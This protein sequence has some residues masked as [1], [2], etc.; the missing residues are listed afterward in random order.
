MKKLNVVQIGTGHDHAYAPVS[1][2]PKREDIR[3]S[4]YVRVEGETK[5]FDGVPELSYNEVLSMR[6]LDAVFIET[7]DQY[8]TKY[9]HEF[10]KRGIAV[11]MDKPG[12]QDKKSFDALFDLASEKGVPLHLGYMYRYN[13]AIK[14]VIGM[15]KNGDLGEIYYI[16]A[17]MNCFHPDEKRKWLKDYQGGMMNFL[18]CHLVDIVLQVQG[19]PDEIIPYNAASEKQFGED[20]GFAVF[21]YGD[22]CSFIK[23]TAV[24]T[25]GFMRRQI[26]VCGEKGTVEIHPTEYFADHGKL[27]SDVYITLDKSWSYKPD[28]ISFGPYDRYGDM[29]DEFFK[30]V[31]GEMKNPY[32]YEYEKL[33]HDTLLKA[34][35]VK[36]QKEKDAFTKIKKEG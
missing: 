29:Y 22:R 27:C 33:L 16:E 26:V 5:T 24:E 36:I 2:L 1:L 14:K 19:V 23:T 15:V 28:K 34:C 9:A 17:Q 11:Q 4:G 35:G 18:G 7:E 32:S 8:L 20:M 13:P 10:V 25:G 6:D 31:R 3:F 21:R 30:I 12:G